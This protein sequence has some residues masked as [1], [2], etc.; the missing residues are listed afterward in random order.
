VKKARVV[1]EKV[2]SLVESAVETVTAAVAPIMPS[3]SSKPQP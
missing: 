2:K 3:D 1:E